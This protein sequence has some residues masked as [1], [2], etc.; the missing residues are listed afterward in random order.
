MLGIGPSVTPSGLGLFAAPAP[1]APLR[2]PTGGLF[3]A[4]PAPGVGLFP[5][6]APPAPG[7]G[8]FPSP[9]PP[10]SG[11]GLFPSP[12]PTAP[13]RAGIVTV[14]V[15]MAAGLGYAKWIHITSIPPLVSG[16]LGSIVRQLT[17]D[18]ILA[19]SYPQQSSTLHDWIDSVI[20]TESGH[21]SYIIE[22]QAVARPFAPT[23][24][25][26]DRIAVGH[27][28]LTRIVINATPR[29]SGPIQSPVPGPAAP[30]SWNSPIV[31]LVNSSRLVPLPSNANLS[32][33]NI[34]SLPG[35]PK[36]VW[37]PK[38]V[39]T[40][41]PALP[42][43]T[44]PITYSASPLIGRVNANMG[45]FGNFQMPI[46]AANNGFA[47][48]AMGL[49]LVGFS[50]PSGGTREIMAHRDAYMSPLMF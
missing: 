36:L 29:F 23:I 21:V 41:T 31:G 28:P 4:P 44:L 37:I 1:V 34:S 26:I 30:T 11:A 2:A 7:V 16:M 6:P 20:I 9:A 47:R 27:V 24:E 17:T 45:P 46:N 25:S 39:I 50:R 48:M 5:S 14:E 13:A 15:T 19:K 32:N 38:N 18:A 42:F 10:A 33:I 49:P 3:S 35:N 22:R 12:A 40:Q 8:L 43:P